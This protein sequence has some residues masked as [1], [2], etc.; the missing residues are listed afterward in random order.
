MSEAGQ[1]TKDVMVIGSEEMTLGFRLAGVKNFAVV[2]EGDRRAF[3][4]ELSK[5]L[6]TERYC[7]I[8]VNQ[9]FLQDIGQRLSKRMSDSIIPVVVGVPDKTGFGSRDDSLRRMIRKTL[10]V[11][12]REGA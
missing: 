6:D 7:T 10:G 3:E 11:E 5:A 9:A 12:I 8:I 4:A 2:A 1:Q